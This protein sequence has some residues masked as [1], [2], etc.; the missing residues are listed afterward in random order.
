MV[1]AIGCGCGKPAPEPP[2]NAAGSTPQTSVAEDSQRLLDQVEALASDVQPVAEGAENA[3]NEADRV[4]LRSRADALDHRRID[5]MAQ[6]ETLR[7]RATEP[8]DVDR[9]SAI[10]TALIAAWKDIAKAQALLA[11]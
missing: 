11:N 1:V 3:Q 4:T 5:L 8:A 9:M 10:H 6:E 2:A 7:K